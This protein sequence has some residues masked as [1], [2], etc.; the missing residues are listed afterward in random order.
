MKVIENF[1]AFPESIYTTLYDKQSRRNDHWKSGA[2][3]G[4]SS[5]QDT[6][7]RTDIFG[8]ESPSSRPKPRKLKTPM[9]WGNFATF[10][11]SDITPDFDIGQRNSKQ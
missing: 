3:A 1:V 4:S 5:F 10:P 7:T 2:A 9:Y 11:R 6:L 8:V